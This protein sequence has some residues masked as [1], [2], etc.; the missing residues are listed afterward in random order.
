MICPKPSTRLR[1][2]APS[3]DDAEF[4]RELV[5]Q[6]AWQRYISAHTL[7]DKVAAQGYI[8]QRLLSHLQR[9]GM[10]LWVCEALATGQPLGLC[11]LLRR[12][13]LPGPDL[14]FALLPE[15]WGQGFGRESA[16]QVLALGFA[17]LGL[18]SVWAIC[19]PENRAS[20]RVLADLGFV[21]DGIYYA[22]EEQTALLRW[23]CERSARG[24][25]ASAA[26]NP[27]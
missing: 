9:E 10:G 5:M 23:I 16:Q 17:S 2:R 19:H 11:G 4:V 13:G 1:F 14:G 8:E 27:G 15:F 3:L 7:A 6:P 24:R 20:Q 18:A 26:S 12:S 21:P 22:P 25:A